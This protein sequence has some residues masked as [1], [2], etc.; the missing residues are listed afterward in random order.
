[1][2]QITIKDIA[3]LCGVGVSTV[4]R[5]INDHPDINTATK[6]MILEVVKEYNYIPN[7]S[8]RNLK[9]YDAKA[10][11]ILVKGMNNPLFS[12]MLTIMEEEIKRNKYAL[13]LRHVKP[14]EDEID[15]AI[16]LENERHLRGIVF[17]GGLFIH[18][19]EKLALINVPFII[20]TVSSIVENMDKNKYSSIAVD[21]RKESYKAVEYLINQGHKKIAI[22]TAAKADQSIGRLRL[23]GYLNALKKY[24]IEPE[25]E[26]IGY[27]PEDC[28]EYSYKNG[29]A[30]M[31]ELLDKKMGFTAVFAISD[32]L[33]IGACKAI[34][35]TGK[36]IPEDYSVVGFDGIEMAGYYNPSI[37]TIS[38]PVN[39]LAQETIHML[40]DVIKGKSVHKH[41]MLSAELSIGGSTKNIIRF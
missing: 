8:A 30:V 11:A 40:F 39:Q 36:S 14:N 6:E 21:D 1:M 13:V 24:G 10:I 17:L 25:E 22:I 16:E 41:K 34:F 35:E 3:K 28:K 23:E 26:L 12:T 20:S 38:Q 7:N 18:S 33:A 37:T 32:I 2:E 27:M 29:Y 4:S 9:R 15:V 31:K 19:E 5:A